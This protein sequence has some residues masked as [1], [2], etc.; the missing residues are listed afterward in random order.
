[1]LEASVDIH[2]GKIIITSDYRCKDAIKSI[3]GARWDTRLRKWSVPVSWTSC[4]ALREEF[5]EGLRIGSDLN[6][7]AAGVAG[8]KAKLSEL[9]MT[10]EDP[11]LASLGE[12]LP[13][14]DVLYPYQK[15]DALA[16]SIAHKYLLMNGTGTGKTYSALAG[17]SL[18]GDNAFPAIIVAP[19]SMLVTWQ[20]AFEEFFPERECR[21]V[22]GTPTVCKKALEP[23]ADAYVVSW[24]SL[25][26]YS[27]VS[28][29]GSIK[30]SED[31]KRDK[32]L[33]AL[34]LQTFVGD[35]AHRVKSATA[36]R[37]RAAW[38]VAHGCQYRIGLTGSPIQDTPEDLYGLF[39]LLYPEDY[40][41]KTGFMERFVQYE[42][43][44]WGG[45]DVIGI[46]PDRKDEFERNFNAC[47]RRVTKDMALDFLP[48]K[49]YETRWVTLPPKHRKAYDSM[50]KTLI[51]E[52]ESSVVVAD[53]QLVRA[54]RLTQ[55]ANAYGDLDS[56]GVFRMS[57]DSP[58]V[59]AFIEDIKDGD[60][61]GEQV[62]IFTDS[63]ELAGVLERA[64][65]K[66]KIEFVSITG[67]VVGDDR[68]AAMDAFQAGKVDF[69]IL[70]RAGGE[71]ITLTA[72]STMV[73][74]M[75][76]WSYIVHLQVEDRVHRIGSEKHDRIRYVDYITEDT[77]EL[78]Q[79]TRL[80]AKEA[81]A[82]EVLRDQELLDLL[83][84]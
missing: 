44:I 63:R 11:D 61:D 66:R 54:G 14:F 18:I 59:D 35:E 4:L 49:I 76:S 19:K 83:K 23:G 33:Q 65:T 68:Q 12:G 31:D 77:V 10:M 78:G 43:N 73:R 82:Q 29:Y 45:R 70:T 26:K 28:G 37:T 75:R 84:R 55:L 74:L 13:K 9:R 15:V 53:N 30:L 3:P 20:R 38:A 64:F 62:V 41:S 7:W 16:I 25:R 80:N 48:P 67:D 69:I 36:Q 24:D 27:R 57:D 17:L 71:G 60:Y 47:T 56:E 6:T 34:G 46:K 39:H 50:E 42:W 1:M 81:R 21:V 32:E 22:S 8:D 79:M 2:D 52:L 72:G 51:A 5:G 40:P 58:K